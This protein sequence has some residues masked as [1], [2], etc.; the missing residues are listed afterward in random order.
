MFDGRLPF[1]PRSA[2]SAAIVQLQSGEPRER[3]LEVVFHVYGIH[4]RMSL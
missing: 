2:Y 1:R 3:A 4:R